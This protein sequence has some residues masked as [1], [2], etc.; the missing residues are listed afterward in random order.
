M[1]P[2]GDRIIVKRIK[3]PEM[4]L[5]GIVLP[6]NAKEKPAEGMVLAVGKGRLVDNGT[7]IA[8]ELRVEDRVLF[9]KYSGSEVKHNGED[10]VILRE[11]DILAIL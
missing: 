8:S 3:A 6:D 9:G 11:E 10:L 7:F 1:K 5:G 4:S 2:I